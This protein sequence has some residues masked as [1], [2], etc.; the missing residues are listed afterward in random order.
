MCRVVRAIVPEQGQEQ[1]KKLLGRVDLVE[2]IVHVQS[3]ETYFKCFF[4]V[5]ID[6]HRQQRSTSKQQVFYAVVAKRCGHPR[7]RVR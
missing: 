1:Y 5:Y 4:F 2:L 7:V 3:A 6:V